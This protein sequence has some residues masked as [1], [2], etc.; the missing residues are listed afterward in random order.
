MI[1][2][3]ARWEEL[4]GVIRIFHLYRLLTMLAILAMLSVACVRVGAV[5]SGEQDATTTSLPSPLPQVSLCLS[6][7]GGGGGQQVKVVLAAVE[8]SDGGQ[9]LPLLHQPMTITSEQAAL[10]PLLDRAQVPAGQYRLLRY[11]ISQAMA[12]QDGREI[13]LQPPSQPVEYQLAKPLSLQNTHSVSLFFHW[14]IAASLRQAPQFVAAISASEQRLPLTTEL[15][16]VS[17][18]EINTVYL[19]RTDQNRICGSWGI[20]GRPTYLK[21]F[22]GKNELYVLAADQ[23]VIKVLE[24]SSGRLKDQ[25]RLPMISKPSFMA[26]DQQGKNA[27]LLDQATDTVYR[28]DLASGSLAAQERIG[29]RLNFAVF[30][31]DQKRLAVSADRS[32]RVLLLD[33]TTLKIQQSLS[34]GS[35]P[36]GILSYN[37]NL[38]VV[39]GLAHAVSLHNVNTGKSLRQQVGRGPSRLLTHNRTLLVSNAIGGSI[40]F[41][42]PDQM[43]V[44]KEISIGGTPGEM[45]V[46]DTRNWLYVNDSKDEAVA[47]LDLANHRLMMRINLQARPLAIDVIQ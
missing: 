23:A 17:C 43:T 16:F 31:E 47:V 10:G 20:T 34:V 25:I 44:V 30:L 35:E 22:K 42:N 11:R 8:L 46:S 39:E 24:L 12:V 7:S 6:S 19:I 32:Q 33:Q 36:Q 2:R 4:P 18:P 5:R 29:E 45:A 41:L 28:I 27:Y 40:S 3:R 14:D 9:W 13:V 26:L 37:K 1:N 15:A 38:Y 21:A